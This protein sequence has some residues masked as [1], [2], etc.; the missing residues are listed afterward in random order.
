MAINLSGAYN[1]TV[2]N[3]YAIGLLSVGNTPVEIKVGASALEG[4]QEILVYNDSNLVVYF[5]DATVTTSTGI[6]I[7]KGELVNLPFRDTL[8]VYLIASGGS[9]TV[10]I[11]ELG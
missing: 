4:R 8:P 2:S 9:N 6:P 5:G 10:R 11:Q 7:E 1:D 3:V